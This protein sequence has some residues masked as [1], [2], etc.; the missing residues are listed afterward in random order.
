MIYVKHGKRY[1]TAS[2]D[3]LRSVMESVELA[4]ARETGVALTDPV[5][6]AAFLHT[7]V[8]GAERERFIVLA[9]DNRHRVLAC[10][11]L[12]EGTID[13]CTVHPREVA[14]YAF[15]HNA[16]AIMLAH[17]HPSGVCEP[18]DADCRITRRIADA[19]ALFDIRVLD[20][21]I[22]S[23]TNHVS[24]QSRGLM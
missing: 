4:S 6:A 3:E 1:K 18:S 23:G 11:A 22:I 21:I 15:E 19:L 12:F 24:L 7:W 20:H 14:K 2:L 9:L 16:A 17:N 8:M 10:T 13:G 5:D